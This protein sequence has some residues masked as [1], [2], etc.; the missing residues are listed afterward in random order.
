MSLEPQYGRQWCC[1]R[2][3]ARKSLG[4]PLDSLAHR[5]SVPCNQGVV[6]PVAR[7]QPERREIVLVES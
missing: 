6:E 3:L 5:E 2:L 4:S 7:G 1:P